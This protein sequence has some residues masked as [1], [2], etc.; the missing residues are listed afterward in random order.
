[1][2]KETEIQVRR[3]GEVAIVEAPEYVNKS[4]GEQI[5]R[6]YRALAEEG[7]TKIVLNLEQ[8]YMVN[9]AGISFLID[10]LE[11]LLVV[12]GAMA[13]CCVSPTIAKTLQIMGLL[14]AASLY[15][16]EEQTKAALS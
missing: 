13:F 12:G 1:M 10:V 14:Q 11:Q 5:E 7:I 8:C 4:S 15:D 6:I 9:S 2:G 16:T 3:A